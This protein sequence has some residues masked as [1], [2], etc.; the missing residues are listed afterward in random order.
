[1]K[2]CERCNNTYT[3]DHAFC[4]DCG[5]PLTD[6]QEAPPT[7]NVYDNQPPAQNAYPQ[8]P[9]QY[10][11]PAQNVYPQQPQQYQQPAQNVYQQ[12]AP[13]KEVGWFGSWGWLLFMTIGLIGVWAVSALG[14][15]VFGIIGFI[16]AWRSGS[17]AKKIVAV[18]LGI[19]VVVS[20][21]IY[22]ILA[23]FFT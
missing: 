2:K 20:L 17:V 5:V 7:Q 9:Q 18:V 16:G 10:Q 19:A 8:Q 4:P 6:I 3:D 1:M 14:G 21:S 11:Q 15:L 23:W 12:P 22:Y 13:A